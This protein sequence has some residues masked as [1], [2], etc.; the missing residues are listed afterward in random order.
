MHPATVRALLIEGSPGDALT[1]TQRLER[2][3]GTRVEVERVATLQ[4]GLDLL[5]KDRTDVVLL[6]LHL[7][8]S[9]GAE[10]VMRVREAY[11]RLPIVVF[12]AGGD[13]DLSMR[14]LQ[15]G[16]QD[17]LGK[18]DFASEALLHRILTS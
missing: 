12:S 16:A 17:Y 6:D 15:A 4:Q 8:D 2:G 18:H 5:G 3:N 10:T 14:S 1:L 13:P 11:P 9:S 7:P